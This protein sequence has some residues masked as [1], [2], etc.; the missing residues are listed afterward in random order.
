MMHQEGRWLREWGQRQGALHTHADLFQS[1]FKP[2]PCRE[3]V[4]TFNTFRQTTS[5]IKIP[6]RCEAGQPK[7]FA[8]GLFVHY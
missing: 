7:D 5:G 2:Q 6:G 4:P 1:I 3:S 8:E